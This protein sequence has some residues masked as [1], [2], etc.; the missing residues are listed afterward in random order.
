M[1]RSGKPCLIWPREKFN[2]VSRQAGLC[3]VAS[4]L[5][6]SHVAQPVLELGQ[7]QIPVRRLPRLGSR[8]G[9]R[10]DRVDQLQ[11]I[12]RIAAVLALVAV[13]FG[14]TAYVALALDVAIGQK[15]VGLHIE[16][17]L[18]FL[19]G[20]IPLVV[21][22]GEE[23][24]AEPGVEIDE[25]GLMRAAVDVELDA[26]PAEILGLAGV[27]PGGEL[28]DAG[29][30]LR[31]EISEATP[32][33]SLPQMKRTSSPRARAKRTNVSAGRYAPAMWPTWSRPFE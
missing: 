27:V 6:S 3:S 12:H 31:A 25:P 24:L 1:A 28:L 16:E 23:L 33:S 13:R 9:D 30:S 21:D 11:R 20:E 8:A 32:L 22:R 19:L 14:I 2:T 18:G 7:P 26:Q 15:L 10:A 17:L 5:L 4:R 29:S